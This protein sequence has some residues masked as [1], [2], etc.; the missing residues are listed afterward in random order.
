MKL[1]AVLIIF[2]T[3][4]FST[5][6][7]AQAPV[8]YR[9]VGIIM[10]DKDTNSVAIGGYFVQK[11]NV[12]L[13]NVI[14][15]NTS[16]SETIDSTTFEAMRAAIESYLISSNLKDSLNFLVT[17]KGVPLRV[18]RYNDGNSP[19][20][21][22]VDADLMLLLGP[23]AQHI[24]EAST[25]VF[26]G[27]GS[28]SLS[29]HPYFQ[30]NTPFTRAQYGMYLVTRLIGL[31][32][33]D[34]FALIDRSGPN[35]LVDKDSVLYVFDKDPKPI[36]V[37]FNNFLDQATTTLRGRGWNVLLNA[38]SVYVT[39]QRNVLGYVS[40][41]SN[42]HYDHL[43]TQYA[44]PNNQ[45]LPASI[46][47]TYVSTSAR[48]F[49]PG[50]EAGQSRIADLIREGCTGASGYV[51]EPYSFSLTQAQ[52]LFE[53]YTNGRN[54]A[55]SFYM[56]N[57]TMSWMA[58]VVGD[59]KTSIITAVPRQPSPS[60]D[61]SPQGPLCQNTVVTLEAHNV[62][63]GAM[64]WFLGDTAL[65]R[66]SANPLDA[67]HPNWIGRDSILARPLSTA[68]LTTF[69]FVNENISGRGFAQLTV[70]VRPKLSAGFTRSADT[71]YLDEN[72]KIIVTDT[73]QGATSREWNFGDGSVT[74]T[75]KTEEHV[76]ARPGFFPITL[77][78]SNGIC[79]QKISST[80][81]LVMHT[82]RPGTLIPES[83]DF[84]TVQVSHTA[85]R[86]LTLRN[87]T[88]D[89]IIIADAMLSGTHAGDFSLSTRTYPATLRALDSMVWSLRF[90]PSDSGSRSAMLALDVS[91]RGALEQVPLE[92]IGTLNP[93]SVS[94]PGTIPL[95]SLDQNYP[96]PLTVVSSRTLIPYTVS[97]TTHVRLEI[98]NSL[99]QTMETLTER[100][101]APGSYA[102]WWNAGRFA[103]GIYLCRIE[104]GGINQSIRIAI[105]R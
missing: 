48:N 52:I 46:A 10:N 94:L 8:D 3:L 88:A 89:P 55:E 97:R 93:V 90:S 47:E 11:R 92:G 16:S 70:D 105:L 43:F 78:A 44:R 31:T 56:A 25:V 6:L 51:Y 64:N 7:R 63:P 103:A 50:G 68:G 27:T 40:W 96:N 4:L 19:R 1:A 20:S 12:P 14:H 74:G 18:S 67:T 69:S 62:Q 36:D 21:A 102:L 59:P 86:I 41:G 101:H 32:K 76:Y 42:D 22:S 79:T 58:V 82:R 28:V 87:N 83:V 38:D 104:A 23:Y 5:S 80:A 73:T 57:P 95:V 72:P 60:V 66:S 30:K 54:L 65:L 29:Y 26:D 49:V 71:L 45:W 15:V 91:Y 81:L 77:T 24:G 37:S 75:N 85:D 34:V 33:E 9:D 39:G 53:R 99:G 13:R 84:G 98:L 35:T 2:V 17:T 61:V 100:I